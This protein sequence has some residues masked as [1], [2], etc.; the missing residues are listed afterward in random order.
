MLAKTRT[1]DAPLQVGDYGYYW[2]IMM[3]KEA[4]RWRPALVCP[5]ESKPP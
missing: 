2:R 1:D 3:D 5:I 4:S